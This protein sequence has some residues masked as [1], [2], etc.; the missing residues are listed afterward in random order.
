MIKGR[1]D[2]T[3]RDLALVLRKLLHAFLH[4]CECEEALANNA[5]L[6]KRYNSAK[7]RTSVLQTSNENIQSPKKSGGDS[8][9]R[10]QS[11]P[12]SFPKKEPGNEA[13]KLLN[14]EVL[15]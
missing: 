9:M 5:M 14:M 11:V 8:N 7:E 15:S 12:G 10:R 3:S 1:R 6:A 13:K 2:I 4:V